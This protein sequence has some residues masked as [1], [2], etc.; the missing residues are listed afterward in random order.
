M[1]RFFN[2]TVIVYFI[3][4]PFGFA[5]DIFY[6][7]DPSGVVHFSDEQNTHQKPKSYEPTKRTVITVNHSRSD[8]PPIRVARTHWKRNHGK[9]KDII[10]SMAILHGVETALVEAVIL[11]ESAYNP[12]AVSQ[13]GARGLMQLMPK[14]ARSYGVTNIH[15][16]IENISGGVK[17]LKDLIVRYDGD[18]DLVLAAYNAGEPAVE[19]YKDVPPFADTIDYVSKVRKYYSHF[20]QIKE[21][22][23]GPDVDATQQGSI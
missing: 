23:P 10:H 5:E 15:D 11:T 21:Y 8:A 9:F 16:P 19:K 18:L 7:E 3:L 4:I 13:K 6:Y 20:A 2:I 17:L 14:T 12:N 1:G 22:I